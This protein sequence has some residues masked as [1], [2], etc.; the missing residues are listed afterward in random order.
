MAPKKRGSASPKL[1]STSAAGSPTASLEELKKVEERERVS[2]DAARAQ[3][4]I[5]ASN[6][7][8]EYIPY[9]GPRPDEELL[10]AV[11]AELEERRQTKRDLPTIENIYSL[12]RIGWK[13]RLQDE[14]PLG[15]ERIHIVDVNQR[16]LNGYTALLMA[17]AAGSA[18][19]VSLLLERRADVSMS[20]SMRADLPIH[21]AAQGGFDVVT[22][23]LVDQTKAKG[24]INT[25]NLTGWTPLHFGVV[26][27]NLT[28]M[29]ILLRAGADI[30]VRN[31][32]LGDPTALHVA[33][34]LGWVDGMEALMNREADVNLR[35]RLNRSP[36]H[37]SAARADAKAVGLLLRSKADVNSSANGHPPPLAMVP[38]DLP[39]S[40]KCRLLLQS[41]NRA[42][43]TGVRTDPHFEH[44]ERP[45]LWDI[46]VALR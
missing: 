4:Y 19:M 46:P 32:Y 21:F 37:W 36:L 16:S 26:G 42:P 41:Y 3:R 27:Q 1:G 40:E 31:P 6:P 45:K 5:D 35:D 7:P 8:E 2:K 29:A 12:H 22:R 25:P 10:Q 34:R 38:T 30:N 28:V 24:L 33:C 43:P 17:A 44:F 20:T 39:T 13:H 23:L 18:E 9:D 14:Q 15:P 11:R